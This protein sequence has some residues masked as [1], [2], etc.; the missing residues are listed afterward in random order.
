MAVTTDED[1]RALNSLTIAKS[2]YYWDVREL[3]PGVPLFDDLQ[4]SYQ[5]RYLDQ[6]EWVLSALEDYIG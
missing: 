4:P 2:L 3:G 6:S 1:L 5:C